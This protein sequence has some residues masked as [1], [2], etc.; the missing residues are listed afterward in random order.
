MSIEP[1]HCPACQREIPVT[2]YKTGK[3]VDE[4]K[5]KRRYE[6]R[7][8]CNRGCSSRYRVLQRENNP[9]DLFLRRVLV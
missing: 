2:V 9:I 5:T 3:Y 6:E 8:F 1:K 7:K 4:K